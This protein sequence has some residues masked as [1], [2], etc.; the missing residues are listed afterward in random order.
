MFEIQECA[1]VDNDNLLWLKSYAS[2][3]TNTWK[4]NNK[5]N[6]RFLL[7]Y[8]KNVIMFTMANQKAIAF[9]FPPAMFE[10]QQPMELKGTHRTCVFYLKK[11]Q[12]EP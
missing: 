2:K 9:H 12:S 7:S 3:P 8:N 4:Q 11:I 5:E 6:A 1:V 10:L